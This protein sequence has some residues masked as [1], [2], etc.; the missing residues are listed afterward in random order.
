MNTTMK[1]RKMQIYV[2]CY[3]GGRL[4]EAP[5]TLVLGE[6]KVAVK[7]IL[8]RWLGENHRYFKVLG[9]DD[10]TYIIRY[11]EEADE[12]ELVMFERPQ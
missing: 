11:D 10:C 7:E 2:E 8:D 9:E 12:W 1:E 6:R 4:N 5:R 3:S